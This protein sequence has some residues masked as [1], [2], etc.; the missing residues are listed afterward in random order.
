MGLVIKRA[1]CVP[2][3]EI[4][5]EPSSD[6]RLTTNGHPGY[7]KRRHGRE[8]P[9]FYGW[10]RKT[11]MYHQIGQALFFLAW[12]GLPYLVWGFVIRCGALRCLCLLQ[13][14]HGLASGCEPIDMAFTIPRL[15]DYLL[16]YRFSSTRA[17]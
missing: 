14:P 17:V 5:C 7:P 10:L 8:S 15:S 11:Y 9:R 13:W 2:P 6:R 4:V 1:V 16:I 12:G 3:S